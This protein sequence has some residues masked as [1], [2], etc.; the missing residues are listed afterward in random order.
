MLLKGRI[1]RDVMFE[2]EDPIYSPNVAQF[3]RFSIVYTR[4]AHSAMSIGYMSNAYTSGLLHT[5]LFYLYMILQANIHTVDSVLTHTPRSRQKARVTRDFKILYK[6]LAQ[7]VEIGGGCSILF[8]QYALCVREFIPST[9][10]SFLSK[11]SSIFQR[12]DARSF[13]P[14]IVQ[15]SGRHEGERVS[16]NNPKLRDSNEQGESSRFHVL[17]SCA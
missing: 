2:L 3:I 9:F 15:Q 12:L 6:K 11:S 4:S 7:Q 16:R 17:V 8:Y 1:R 10:G 13:C 14:P 5:P